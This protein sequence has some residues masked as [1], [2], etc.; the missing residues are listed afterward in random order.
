MYRRNKYGA[1]K[2]VI[3]GIKFD[4]KLEAKHYQ[5]L[6]L[7]ELAGEIKDLKLQVNF[8]L[9]VNSIKIATY[10]ADFTFYEFEVYRVAD[11]KGVITESFRLKAKLFKAI[12]GYDILLLR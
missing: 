10:R 2:I 3:D 5:I 8:P 7:R 9:E 12:Y 11:A 1:K 6:K 4:S